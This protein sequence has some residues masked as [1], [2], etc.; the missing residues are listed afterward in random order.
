MLPVL[1]AVGHM[2]LVPQ[3]EVD[4]GTCVGELE[5][6][7]FN[8]DAIQAGFEGI[9]IKDP[10]ASYSFKRSVS[11]LKVKPVLTVDL[12][13]INLE[14]GTGKNAGKLGALICEGIDQDKFI[15][16]NV[17]SGLTDEQRDE[18]W[19]DRE[20]V[21]GQVIEVKADCITQS[22]DSESVYSLRFPRF[23]RFRG[24]SAGDKL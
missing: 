20:N 4:L 1:E 18:I 14:E 11:W 17:G 23:E 2:D 7:Q 22:Q 21:I 24:F 12:T 6:R 10:S 13:I 16:V 8:L 15:R 5:F 9:L 3:Q 19:S